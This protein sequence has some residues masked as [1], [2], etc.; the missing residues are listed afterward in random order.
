MNKKCLNSRE[1]SDAYLIHICSLPHS[2]EKQYKT[3]KTVAFSQHCAFHQL[4]N[5]TVSTA[6]GWWRGAGGSTERRE[7]GRHRSFLLCVNI[8]ISSSYYESHSN[9][10]NLV[11]SSSTASLCSTADINQVHVFSNYLVISF[12][13]FLLSTNR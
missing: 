9:G 11:F 2:V 4:Q 6:S 3:E 7:S 13:W 1:S 8:F 12:W 5:E 10:L